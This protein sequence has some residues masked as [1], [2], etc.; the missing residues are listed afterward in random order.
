[1]DCPKLNLPENPTFPPQ[2]AREQPETHFSFCVRVFVSKHHLLE[3]PFAREKIAML[4]DSHLHKSK[5]FGLE[6]FVI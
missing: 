4:F 1:M 3:F 5:R 6:N 2:Y